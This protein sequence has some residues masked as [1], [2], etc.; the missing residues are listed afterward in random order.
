MSRAE[1]RA[2][3]RMTKNVDPY[4]LPTGSAAA[5]SRSERAKAR[6]E[7]RRAERGA[8]GS[9][10]RFLAW[11]IGGAAAA[12]LL[13]FS[14]AW[15]NGMPVALYWGAAGAAAWVGTMFFFRAVQRWLGA[16]R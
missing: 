6:R 1:R 11:T 10:R 16:R 13:A 9:G 14:V 8:S 7:T 15:P 3:K 5:R 2:Y 4:A 12:A